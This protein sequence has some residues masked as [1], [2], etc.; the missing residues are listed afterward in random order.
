MNIF[1]NYKCNK[2][3]TYFLRLYILIAHTAI[4]CLSLSS[5]SDNDKTDL[6]STP[7][8]AVEY[9]ITKNEAIE[10]LNSILDNAYISTRNGERKEIGEIGF[11]TDRYNALTRG[12]NDLDTIMYIINFKNDNG[13]ALMPTDRRTDVLYALVDKGNYS[14][15]DNSPG[16]QLFMKMARKYFYLTT[17]ETHNVKNTRGSYQ[18]DWT[19]INQ[20][21]PKLQYK[22][23]QGYPFNI[24]C[25]QLSNGS[26]TAVGCTAVAAGMILAMN[27]KPV[28]INGY[29]LNWNKISQ[30]KTASD[31]NSDAIGKEQ[32][33][34][35][36][37]ELGR[38]MNMSY[39]TE[40]GA[41]PNDAL[42]YMRDECNLWASNMRDYVGGDGT[43]N[44]VIYSTLHNHPLGLVMM[45]GYRNDGSLLKGHTW[46]L[47]GQI[48]MKDKN[49]PEDMQL[50]LYH[51]N[52]GWGGINDGYYL[53][54]IFDRINGSSLEFTEDSP[55]NYNIN[56][57]FSEIDGTLLTN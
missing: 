13:F 34:K 1:S 21:N 9:N 33:A 27:K 41:W 50:D 19:L 51:C 29:T 42:K 11:I 55:R 6:E 40:S 47:D 18:Y 4:L 3:N 17:S 35:F 57:Q 52:W 43:S 8:V 12:S 23:N 54:Y 53:R 15:T 44:Y 30:M 10:I 14:E 31:L 46:V 39:G 45:S 7:K 32:V 20:V 38:K 56:L 49:N 48:F 37:Y 16:F 28:S 26:N 5:C 36:L 24:Y 2:M 25:P 22:W